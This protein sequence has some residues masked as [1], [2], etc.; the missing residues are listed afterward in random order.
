MARER[1][2]KILP[3]RILEVASARNGRYGEWKA[4]RGILPRLRGVMMF[5]RAERTGQR[6][7][8]LLVR[9]RTSRV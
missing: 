7:R 1:E 5:V 9:A 8:I 3:T 6:G 4:A 2:Q